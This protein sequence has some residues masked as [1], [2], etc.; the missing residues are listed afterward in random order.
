VNVEQDDDG[1]KITVTTWGTMAAATTA[2]LGEGFTIPWSFAF[3]EQTPEERAAYE[4]ERERAKAERDDRQA[5][6]LAELGQDGP[7]GR[8]VAL[9]APDEYGSCTG[10]GDLDSYTPD[11]PCET[12]LIATGEDDG[13]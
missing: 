9:H 7:L 10:C 1:L 4:A 8:I 3:R 5:D 11:W 6:W 12:W 2:E 13:A